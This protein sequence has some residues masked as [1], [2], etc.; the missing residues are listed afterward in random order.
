MLNRALASDNAECPACELVVSAT[1]NSRQPPRGF[2]WDMARMLPWN[3]FAENFD[4][5]NINYIAPLVL[6]W[7]CDCGAAGPNMCSTTGVAVPMISWSGESVAVAS[8]ASYHRTAS[9]PFHGSASGSR[10]PS[11]RGDH[12]RG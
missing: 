7:T 6:Q 9:G 12:G 10:R 5:R 1:A 11:R 2:A 3:A 4:V 8:L